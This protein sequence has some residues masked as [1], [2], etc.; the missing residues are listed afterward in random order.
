MRY[1]PIGNESEK[2]TKA[3]EE[4]LEAEIALRDQREKVAALRRKLPDDTQVEDYAF[5]TA[6]AELD[7]DGPFPMIR[8]SGL[9]DDPAK[10]L[11]VYQYMFGGA[12]KK[13]CNM[14][15][16]WIDG[17]NGIGRHLR[18]SVNFAIVAEVEIAE[19]HKWARH[20]GWRDLRM[21]SSAGSTFKTDLQFQDAK[22]NQMPGISVFRRSP[23]GGKHFYSGSA[24][25]KQ[26]EFRGL[27][28]LTPLWNILDLTPEGRG[29]FMPKLEYD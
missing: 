22:G 14:C 12:Q 5:H 19:L 27:D 17:F 9:F 8:L 23:D 15:T 18:Q 11:V 26:N 7:K 20:R 4:L 16:L 28:L 21:V 6:P 2:Y 1:G 29:Q 24:I 25:M 13:P 10:P 3:R